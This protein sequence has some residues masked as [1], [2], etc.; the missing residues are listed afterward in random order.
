MLYKV[1]ESFFHEFFLQS[2]MGYDGK[3]VILAEATE[4]RKLPM[5]ITACSMTMQ[6]PRG[7]SA[8]SNKMYIISLSLSPGCLTDQQI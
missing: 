6:E 3:S 5:V 1:T 8:E 4:V 7:S 2:T